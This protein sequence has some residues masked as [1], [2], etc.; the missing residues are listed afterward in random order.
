[1]LKQGGVMRQCPGL[2]AAF[3]FAMLLLACLVGHLAPRANADVGTTVD[4]AESGNADSPDTFLEEINTSGYW[5]TDKGPLKLIVIGGKGILRYPG[6]EPAMLGAIVEGNGYFALFGDDGTGECG[7]Y[8]VW[9][10]VLLEPDG[11][12]RF[13]ASARICDHSSYRFE[14][15]DGVLVA[16]SAWFSP[17]LYMDEA[18]RRPQLDMG[19]DQAN[20]L[21]Q[22]AHGSDFDPA[23]A[24]SFVFDMSCD[25]GQD[26]IYLWNSSDGSLHLSIAHN[27][28]PLYEGED[29]GSIE[30]IELGALDHTGRGCPTE[31]AG[32]FEV[33]ELDMVLSNLTGAPS[34]PPTCTKILVGPGKRCRIYWD[35]ETG[36]FGMY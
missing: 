8:D 32:D 7:P 34:Y 35:L 5:R 11:P 4:P 3:A 12:D 10:R 36:A 22:R 14:T 2:A 6:F 1:M 27:Q 19:E 24:Q 13:I 16:G 18:V 17:D 9:G 30:T 20:D 31:A 29:T 33:A 26:Q 15:W 25:G 21:M 28:V 23:R